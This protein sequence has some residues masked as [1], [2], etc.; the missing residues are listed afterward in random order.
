MDLIMEITENE[1]TDISIIL[2]T[3]LRII[4]Q[5]KLSYYYLPSN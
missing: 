3:Q 4:T 2:K 1:A 5:K